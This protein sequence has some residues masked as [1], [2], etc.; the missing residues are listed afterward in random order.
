MKNFLIKLLRFSVYVVI[1][2]EKSTGKFKK[3]YVFVNRKQA[4]TV[5]ESLIV[6]YGSEN[7]CFASRRII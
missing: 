4:Y 3:I 1:A 2:R 7:A 6:D 5:W